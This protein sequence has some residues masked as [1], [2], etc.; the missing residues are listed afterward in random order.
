MVAESALATTVAALAG[1]TSVVG[2]NLSVDAFTL[3]FF[4]IR[5]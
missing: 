3:R 2:T 1:T 5:P 4:G